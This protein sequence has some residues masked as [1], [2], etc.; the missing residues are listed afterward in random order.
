MRPIEKYIEA[1]QNVTIV[2]WLK[3]L[4]RTVHYVITALTVQGVRNIMYMAVRQLT[5]FLRINLHS[6]ST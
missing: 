5:C 2:R 3:Y 4:L 6:A 1:L